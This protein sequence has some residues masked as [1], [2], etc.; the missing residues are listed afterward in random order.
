MLTS[1]VG[2][3]PDGDYKNCVFQSFYLYS[4]NCLG[5]S[6]DVFTDCE[7]YS[8]E[9]FKDIP[10]LD[11]SAVL[12]E[13]S[14]VLVVNVVNRSETD[15]IRTDILLQSG[16]YGGNAK[17]SEVNAATTTARNTK[18]EENVSIRTSEIKFKNNTINYSF[19]AHSLTQLEIPV[20]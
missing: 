12:N 7:K 11:V 16:N 10:Y 17:V 4:N 1:L 19:P 20:K 3:S 8:N 6:L 15:A 5:T 18:T 2:Y 13:S 14:G 9:V